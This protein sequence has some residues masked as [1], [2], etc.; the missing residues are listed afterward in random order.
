MPS[1]QS[2]CQEAAVRNGKRCVPLGRSASLSG[3]SEN[4]VRLAARNAGTRPAVSIV[5]EG[6]NESHDQG[7]IDDTLAALSRQAYPLS[8][9]HLVLVGSDRQAAEW[10]KAFAT[11]EP[12]GSIRAVAAPDAHY[13]A[14]KNIGAAL[15]GDGIIAF[16]DS[17]VKPDPE[18][19][20]AIAE[21]LQDADVAVGVSRFQGTDARTPG[22]R[23]RQVASA[24]T[25]AWILGRTGDPAPQ[26]FLAHNVAFRTEI[27][28]AH[29]YGVDHGRTCGSMLMYRD[30]KASG[31]RIALQ[32]RQQAAHYFT[33]GWWLGKFHYRAGYEVFRVRRL[34]AAYPHRWIRRLHLLEP[35]VTMFWHCAHDL[36]QWFPYSR[37]IG[38]P[39]ALRVLL[40][41]VLV[42]LSLA[43]R[44]AEMIGM[45]ATIASPETM[46]RWAESS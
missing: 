11:P 44:G 29:R 18:W 41:P 15:A 23:L 9:V 5:I 17:D 36:R 26:G 10:Q 27:F 22:A 45:Y 14:L 33:W 24:I 13:Y 4:P 31:L 39:A 3:V 28:R 32:P 25:Y 12:F 40:L 35:L 6:Y 20:P 16:T 34:D 37:I 8:R 38:V 19:L 30:L 2:C 46:R 42:P 43:A 7:A 21:T 1:A